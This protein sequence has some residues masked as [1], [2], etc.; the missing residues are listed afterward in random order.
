[1]IN[2]N[3]RLKCSMITTKPILDFLYWDSFIPLF[4]KVENLKGITII[5]DG[6]EDAR[7]YTIFGR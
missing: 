7:Y 2:T 5:N 1:M 6:Q 4:D 3:A